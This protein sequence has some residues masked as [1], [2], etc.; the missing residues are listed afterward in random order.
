MAIVT[1][2]GL[3]DAASAALEQRWSAWWRRHY[4]RPA[5]RAGMTLT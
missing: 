4:R 5:E 1:T 3:D 2:Y